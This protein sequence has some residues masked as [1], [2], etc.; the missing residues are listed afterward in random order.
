M[1]PTTYN[2][3]VRFLLVGRV[4][5]R[6]QMGLYRVAHAVAAVLVVLV[7]IAV[8]RVPSVP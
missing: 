7:V 3:H 4:V 8:L 5:E 6:K 2:F 1:G